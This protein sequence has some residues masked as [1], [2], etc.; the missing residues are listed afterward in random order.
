VLRPDADRLEIGNPS[1]PGAYVLN[2]ALE[3]LASLMARNVEQHALD[4]GARVREGLLARSF[5]VMTPDAPSQRAG[6]TCFEHSEPEE[7]AAKLAE[8]GVQVW[9]SDGRVRVSG[10][11]YNSSDD[12]ERFF[13]ALDDIGRA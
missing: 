9:G 3:R 10:H 4:L 13:A 8:R 7:L 2:N 5:A 11:V 12:V 6:N 1:F